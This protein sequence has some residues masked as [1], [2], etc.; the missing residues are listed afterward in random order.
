MASGKSAYLYFGHATQEEWS[1]KLANET[2]NGGNNSKEDMKGL[3]VFFDNHPNITGLIIGNLEYT[4]RT[5]D[6]FI[7]NF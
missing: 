5:K 2:C 6:L 4:V 1:I 7:F 3:K